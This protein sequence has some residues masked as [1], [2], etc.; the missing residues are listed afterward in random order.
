MTAP[1]SSPAAE[2]ALPASPPSSIDEARGTGPNAPRITT[3][4]YIGVVAVFLGLTTQT[5][6]GRLVSVGLPDLRGAMGAGFDEASWIPTALNMGGIF[7]GV[8]A[9]FLAAAYGIRRVL[10]V[11]S[12]VFTLSTLLLP[13]S[14]TLAVMLALLMLS[15]LSSGSFYTLTMT[16]VAGSLPPKLIIFGIAA[17]ALDVVVTNNIAASLEGFY[18]NHLSW[19]WIF[20]TAA[21]LT[22]LV[23]IFIW[24]G[25]PRPPDAAR[26]AP[27]PSWRGFLYVGLGLSLTYA[28][29]DQGQRLDWLNSGLIAGFF[30]AAFVLFAAA[31]VRRYRQ[32]N[33]FVNLPFLNAR[34]IIILGLGIFFIRFSLLANLV[35]IPAFLAN[36]QQYRPIQTGHSLAWVAAPQFV[37][38]WLVAIAMVFIPPRIVMAAGFSTIAVACWMAAH[39]DSAW[40]GDSFQATELT[41]AVGVAIAFVGLVTNLVL[42][43]LESGAVKDIANIS[44]FSGW[45]H[46]VRLLGGQIGVVIFTRFLDVHEKW[47]SNLLGQYVDPGNWLTVERLNALGAALTP[48]SA[49]MSDAQARSVGLLSAQVRVQSYTLASADAFMLIAWAIVGYLVLLVFLR[50]STINLRQGGKAQ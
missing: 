15:G 33:P 19:H 45:V 24:F 31:V 28:A 49:S 42:L 22:P 35:M 4:P 13:F 1:A 34:N 47:H 7:I 11:S 3:H 21:L 32:P 2:A 20:W 8:F 48:S 46:T 27:K 30:A 23:M 50:P 43:A 37:L 12:V 5:I 40:S 39:L 6:Y 26:L 10:L 38:V 44:T 36:I 17:Y 9:V 14:P 16:F 25:I 29:L 41:F 18:I